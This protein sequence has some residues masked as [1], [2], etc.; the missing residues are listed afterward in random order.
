MN[1]T[2]IDSTKMVCDSPPLESVNPEMWY[3]I[4]VSLDGE[5]VSDATS[6]FKYYH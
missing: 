2:V 6:L 4:S 1:A 5:F 3:N